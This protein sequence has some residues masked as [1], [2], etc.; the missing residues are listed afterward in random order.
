[1]SKRDFKKYISELNK[2]QLEQQITDLYDKFIDVKIYYDF[3]FNPN[4]DRLI[5]DA[6]FKISNEYFPVRGKKPK[7]RRSVA[8]K[9]IKHFIILGVDIF[10]IADVML[11][12]IE[13]AQTFSAEKFIKQ[14]QFFKSMLNSFQFIITFLIENGILNEFKNR[15]VA[16]KEQAIQQNWINSYEFNA[17]IERFEY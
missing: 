11:Y 2:E 7:M 4:E 17:I 13:I 6:K 15:V 10:I 9:I 14:E 8:Q 12:N 1:M 3:A 5:R 16:I